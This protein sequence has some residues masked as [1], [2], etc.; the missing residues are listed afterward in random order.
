MIA[1]MDTLCVLGGQAS[2]SSAHA[3][4]IQRYIEL[5]RAERL[6]ASQVADLRH[7]KADRIEQGKAWT[8]RQEVRRH[9][10]LFEYN[11]SLSWCRA[12]VGSMY[13]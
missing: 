1:R 9:S 12:C 7:R 10:C 5:S 8:E 4:E 3:A 11:T 2:R 6:A 13:T